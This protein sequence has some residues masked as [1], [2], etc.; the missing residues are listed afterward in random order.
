[1]AWDCSVSGRGRSEIGELMEQLELKGVYE[2]TVY[3]SEENGWTVGTIQMEG[4]RQPVTIVGNFTAVPGETLALSGEWVTNPKFGEQFKV[5]TFQS[6]APATLDGLRKYL[7][8]GMIHGIG[9]VYAERLIERFG[10]EVPH[11]IEEVPRRLREVAGIG[12]SRQAKIIEGWNAQREIKNVMLFL[13]SHGVGTAHAVK[14]Y[15][16]YQKEAITL[17]TENPYRLAADVDGIGFKT[18]DDIAQRLNIAR[19]SQMRLK[20]GILH[21]LGEMSGREGHTGYPQD[22]LIERAAELLEVKPALVSKALAE[23]LQDPDAG[24]AID[25]EV[26]EGQSPLIY[27]RRLLSAECAS[28]IA[29]RTIAESPMGNDRPV[30]WENFFTWYHTHASVEFSLSQRQAIRTAYEAKVSLITGGPGT[31]KSTLVQAVTA[32]F[33]QLKKPV[34]LAAPTGR[35]AQRL[36]EITKLEAKTI[37][38]L[39]EFDPKTWRFKKDENNPLA[40]ELLIVDEL[41]MV[42]MSLFHHLVMAVP[43]TARLLFVGD[44]DQLPSVGPGNVLRDL[45]ECQRF[46]VTRLMEVYR[47]AA[48]SEIIR[49]AYRINQGESLVETSERGAQSDFFFMEK[50][51]P[52]ECVALIGRLCRDYIPKRLRFAPRDIQVLVP[53]NRGAVGTQ[54]L[55]RELQKAL[56]PR[57]V[58][59]ER[60]AK[61]FCVGDRVIQIRNNYD[62]E[63]FNGDIGY[64]ES[65]D[66]EESGLAVRFDNRTVAYESSDLD[67]LELAYAISIHKSQ[68]SEFPAV[69]IPVMPQHTVLLQR[70][71]L[72]T[73]VT[74]GKRLVIVVGSRSAIETAIKNSRIDQRFG[75]FKDRLKFGPRPTAP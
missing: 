29:L 30:Q 4:R 70:N 7:G 14:I 18:A 50:E 48:H 24:I 71:L 17:V 45:L 58:G 49:N 65:I 40:C 53:M 60:G 15:K 44:A 41:S 57:G 22:G 20:A 16:I 74:R 62:R 6:S 32:L 46:P 3:S 56:N 43:P 11:I 35:A 36:Q 13:Q 12:K 33:T 63:V 9:P 28:A 69:V 51:D 21:V 52:A 26:A 1:M 72:Y 37:H 54:V 19:D 8:S 25:R 23:V 73:A 75:K 67:E 66:T 39:L 31:G 68:G 10:M 64:I 2:H 61:R 5:D 47:Q 42:D 59:I 34:L 38:R 55:N 27:L